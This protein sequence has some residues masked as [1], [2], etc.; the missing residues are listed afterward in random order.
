MSEFSD[1]MSERFIIFIVS[2]I[3]IERQLCK[4]YSG[5]HIYG[6]LFRAGTS[7]GANYEEAR[8]AESTA[9]FVHKMQLVLKE[10]RESHFWISVI[11]AGELMNAEN[12]V[13]KFLFNESKELANIIAKSVITS[14]S[15]LAKNA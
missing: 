5:R 15:K 3:K 12:E 7:S 10:L 13:L 1:Q 14:K 4:T 11:I 8:A 9:D 2:I 6:Q